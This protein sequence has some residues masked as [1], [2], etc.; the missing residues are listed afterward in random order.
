MRSVAEN[1]QHSLKL[2]TRLK[3]PHWQGYSRYRL[4]FKYTDND[5][6]DYLSH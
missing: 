3:C 6:S 2:R 4:A 5:L 1:I